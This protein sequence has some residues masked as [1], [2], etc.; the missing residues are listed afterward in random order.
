VVVAA[1]CE[2]IKSEENEPTTACMMYKTHKPNVEGK[3]M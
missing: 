3:R 2:R 1:H